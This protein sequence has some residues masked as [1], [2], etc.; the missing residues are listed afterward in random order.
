MTMDKGQR[1]T[2]IA[3]VLSIVSVVSAVMITVYIPFLTGGVG[4]ILACLARGGR[5]YFDGKGKAAM[6]LSGIGIGL[7][8]FLIFIVLWSYFM[9]PQVRQQTDAL[10]QQNYGMTYEQMMA[11]LF[12][13]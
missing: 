13:E 8:L 12:G 10:F 7:N 9:I 11:Q 2:V 1:M 4:M 3:L 5:K 6:I